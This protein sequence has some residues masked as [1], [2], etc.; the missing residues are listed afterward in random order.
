MGVKGFPYVDH[1]GNERYANKMNE[2]V[3]EVS[4]IKHDVDYDGDDNYLPTAMTVTVYPEDPNDREEIG[5][6]A[7]E[8]I[9]DS[10]G[11]Y[12]EGF[13]IDRVVK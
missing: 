13:I 7:S 4:N 11:F 12:H 3:V 10:T 8:A 9:S 2:V 6:L 1:D 5:E